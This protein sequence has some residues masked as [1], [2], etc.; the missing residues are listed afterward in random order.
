VNTVLF[1]YLQNFLLVSFYVLIIIG[2]LLVAV[3]FLTYLERKVIASVQYRKGPNVVGFFGLLQPFADGI[4]LFSKETIIPAS[5][6]KIIFVLAPM[7]TFSLSMIAWSV[8]PID[9]GIVLSDINVGILYIFAVSS[10][11]IYGVIMAGWASNSKYAFLGALR[12]TAQMVSYEVSIGLVIVC[13][14]LCVGSLNLQEIVMA[15]KN[16]WFLI[17]LFPMFIVFVISALAET[18]RAPFDLPEDESALVAG[19]FTEYSSMLFAMF[20][21]GEY[22]AMILMSSLGTILF[23]GGWL[24]PFDLIFFNLIPGFVWFFLKVGLLLFVFLW[25]RATLPRFRYDQLMRL[26]WKVFLP[27]SLLWVIITSTVLVFFDLLPNSVG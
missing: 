7:V 14:L 10:L 26:G 12:S 22:S 16:C 27:L 20:F 1:E 5:A 17:P 24:P 6:N 4:K 15:Q 11:S 18:N 25:V 3:A 9:Q 21:L 13:V 2:P 8:I 19:Y 23:L